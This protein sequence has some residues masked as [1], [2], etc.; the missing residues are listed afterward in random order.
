[1][2]VSACTQLQ[3]QTRVI[4]FHQMPPIGHGETF[5]IEPDPDKGQVRSVEW[6][7]YADLIAQQLT[8]KGYVEAVGARNQTGIG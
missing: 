5:I 4:R 2:I 1:L 7:H 6:R 3:P 8:S